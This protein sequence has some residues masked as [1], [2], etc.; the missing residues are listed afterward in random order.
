MVCLKNS[1]CIV[2]LKI[3]TCGTIQDEFGLELC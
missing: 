1:K 2:P 3:T